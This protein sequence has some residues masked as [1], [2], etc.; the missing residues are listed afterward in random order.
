MTTVALPSPGDLLRA[1]HELGPVESA[2][3]VRIAAMLDPGWSKQ[4]Q[5]SGAPEEEAVEEQPLTP[6]V[7]SEGARA[8][9]A[10]EPFEPPPSS[11]LQSRFELLS[12]GPG[13]RPEWLEVSLPQLPVAPTREGSPALQPLIAPTR[14]RGI[15]VAMLSSLVETRR[16]DIDEAV[17]MVAR[18]MNLLHPPLARV[19]RL[20]PRVQL[21]V[22][23]SETMLPFAGDLDALTSDL[24]RVVGTDRLDVLSFAGCPTSGA[25]RG[26]RPR[27]SDYPAQTPPAGSC[28]LVATDAGI[29]FPP[30]SSED[31]KSTRLNSSHL[32]LSRMP[33]S[34]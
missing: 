25:G 7:G 23:R 24:Q 27:W 3:A 16:L 4:P 18:G 29:G 10:P 8:A 32:K 22:D 33:S 28:V 1:L 2:T 20:A 26:V 21:L 11:V 15:I 30:E 31:R 12:S 17:R 9:A 13:E 6:A 34:A 19:R 14:A 5:P